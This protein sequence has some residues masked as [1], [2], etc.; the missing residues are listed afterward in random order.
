M[1]VLGPALTDA[2]R[3]AFIA[4]A[5]S[6]IGTRWKHQGRDRR[7]IDCG[8]L[9]LASLRD[10]G[11]PVED[12]S[13]GYGREPYRHSMEAVCALNLGEPVSEPY[14][15]RPGDVAL[16]RVGRAAPNHVGI[17]GDYVHGGL[18]LIHAY[19]INGKVVEAPLDASWLALLQQV[20][21]V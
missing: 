1:R 11:K 15:L 14:N 6:Y 7:G 2:E 16:F 3:A 12:A 17:V 5:R 4:A 18:S 9:V 13:K 10:I 19:A 21:A 8:G 20:Y